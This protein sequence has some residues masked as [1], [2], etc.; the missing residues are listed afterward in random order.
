VRILGPVLLAILTGVQAWGSFEFPKNLGSKDRDRITE[1][2]GLGNSIKLTANPYPLGGYSGV[3][4]SYGVEQINTEDI[5]KLG[6]SSEATQKD[7]TYSRISAGKGLYNNVDVFVNFIP[8]SETIG[9]SEYGGMLR[10]CFYQA[11][12]IPASF[13][14]IAHANS[15]NVGNVFFSQTHG[16][17]LLSGLNVGSLSLYVGVGEVWASALFSRVLNAAENGVTED[18]RTALSSLHTFVGGAFDFEPYFLAV[19]VD[20]YTEAVFSGKLGL[21]F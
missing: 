20:Q 6:D 13:S 14:L 3:E 9:Y 11:A 17:E 2:I 16:L 4:L 10:Y 7:F 18:R 21:R 5:G 19:Q 8:Y 12:F 15:S 1:I